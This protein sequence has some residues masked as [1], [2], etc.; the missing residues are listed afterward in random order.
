MTGVQYLCSRVIVTSCSTAAHDTLQQIVTVSSLVLLAADEYGSPSLWHPAKVNRGPPTLGSG[1]EA[2]KV[3]SNAT[4]T[5]KALGGIWG[6]KSG[7]RASRRRYEV[8]V[9]NSVRLS[10]YARN[11]IP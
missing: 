9:D 7:A 8:T 2:A 4:L 3:T 1:G 5:R 11:M 6:L 10:S